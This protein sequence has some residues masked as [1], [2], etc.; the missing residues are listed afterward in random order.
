MGSEETVLETTASTADLDARLDGDLDIDAAQLIEEIKERY[1]TR[2]TVPPG[3]F[4]LERFMNEMGKGKTSCRE[5]LAE[6]EKAGHLKRVK[7]PIR[8]GGHRTVWV[9]VGDE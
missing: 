8:T 5:I 1:E 9:K 2:F 7:L 6:E 3:A 4:T